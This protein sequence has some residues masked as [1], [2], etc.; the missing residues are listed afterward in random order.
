MDDSG[1]TQVLGLLSEPSH[2]GRKGGQGGGGTGGGREGGRPASCAQA[3]IPKGSPG[4]QSPRSLSLLCFCLFGA[5]PAAYRGSQ[6]RDPIGAVAASLHHS[7]R[8]SGSEPCSATY[9]IAHGNAKS[10]TQ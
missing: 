3:S 2:H 7:H 6:A 4:F 10:L 9:T 8:N 5:T 1:I